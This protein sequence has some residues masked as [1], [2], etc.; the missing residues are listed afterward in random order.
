MSV[1]YKYQLD[2]SKTVSHEMPEGAEILTVGLQQ[3]E[4]ILWARVALERRGHEGPKETRTFR[5]YGTG[6]PIQDETE[7]EYIG[8]LYDGPFV[9]HV[10]EIL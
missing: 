5:I 1:I 7:V 8:T 9:W 6:H 3:H 4:I 10:F 2:L